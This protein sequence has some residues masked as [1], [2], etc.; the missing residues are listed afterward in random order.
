MPRAIKAPTPWYGG[1]QYLVNDLAALLPPHQIYVEVFG[2]AAALLFGKP[3]S[4]VETYN[5]LD[6]GLVNFFRVLRDAK[7]AK[8][9]RAQ[10]DLTPYAREEWAECCVTWLDA[11]DEV[12]MARRWYLAVQGSFGKHL[13]PAGT[14]WSYSK[15]P[16]RD[17]AH[18]FRAA[19]DEFPR[20]T[21][22]LRHVQI[23][24]DSF[25]R[26]I[27][28]Y[29]GPDTLL[30]C[31]PPYLPETRTRADR[32][33]HELSRDDHRRLLDMLINAAGMVLL[34]GYRSELYD[35][36][37]AGW[38]RVDIAA[39]VCAANGARPK[40]TECVWLNP[41]AVAANERRQASLWTSG[42][43]EAATA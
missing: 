12:E 3:P 8:Q 13:G 1:K 36:A 10:L 23:D 41:A 30:Y 39:H 25:E 27:R 33:R 32:Y 34:S 16:G 11:P 22:R 4:P 21:R 29:A 24:H 42:E 5:D 18:S 40:R 19:V 37:L 2:G 43:G 38:Q 20:F 14:G 17:K 26:V 31:D 28:R 35:L 15:T 6:S 9:L 7:R